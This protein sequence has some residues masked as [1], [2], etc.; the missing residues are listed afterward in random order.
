MLPPPLWRTRTLSSKEEIH[1]INEVG[2]E[3]WVA[4][5]GADVSALDMF[6]TGYNQSKSMTRTSE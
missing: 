2:P 5:F 3:F 1:D 4:V 6:A